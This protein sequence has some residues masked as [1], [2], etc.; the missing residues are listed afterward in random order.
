MSWTCSW[1][2]TRHE[3]EEQR[4]ACKRAERDVTTFAIAI[5]AIAVILFAAAEIAWAVYVYGDWTCAV[6]DCRKVFP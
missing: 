6:A 2:A 4:R 1:C 3:T 5:L